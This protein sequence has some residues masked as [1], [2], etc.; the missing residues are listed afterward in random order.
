MVKFFFAMMFVCNLGYVAGQNS[1]IQGM[2]STKVYK[3]KLK[4]KAVFVGNI[5]QRD[6]MLIV[7]KTAS[8]PR[9]DIPVDRIERIDEVGQMGAKNGDYWF[10]NSNA[11]RYLFG[12]SAF[13]LKR[14]EGYYQNAYLALNS[15][16][17]GVTD[18]L[19]LG[20]G[21]ELFSTF[22]TMIT[23]DFKP[24]FFL[25][26]K[27]SAQV[28]EK[29]HAG[30]GAFYLSIPNSNSRS[31][32]GI[33]YGIGTYGTLDHNLTCGLGWGFDDEK[34]STQPV[35]TL[36]GMTRTSKSTALVSE[37]W[38]LYNNDELLSIY[39]YGI[40]FFG[41]KI[42]V[43]LAFLNNPTIAQVIVIGI[44]YVDFVVKF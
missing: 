42:S 41:E 38:F 5:V 19:T 40:R 11:T 32:Y 3:I 24:V 12:P 43:D 1:P 13:N 4:D 23:N 10:P 36:S 17:V 22:T 37:N 28:S 14:G 35:F 29:F 33:V 21:F 44:P 8:V 31:G 9:I 7:M 34:F 20:G 39:S 25:T 27:I 26:P 18:Y 30:G 2:D 15:F 6:S 16:N